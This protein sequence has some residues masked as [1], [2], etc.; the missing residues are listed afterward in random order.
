MFQ[1][2][3]PQGVHLSTIYTASQGHGGGVYI[4]SNGRASVRVTETTFRNN[5]ATEPRESHR[6]SINGGGVYVSV[7]G[8]IAIM[9]IYLLTHVTFLQ[10]QISQWKRRSCTCVHHWF[11][12]HECKQLHG[13]L[14]LNYWEREEPYRLMVAMQM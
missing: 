11:S 4:Y 10:T 13:Q 2:Q 7:T 12:G 8:D 6:N 9:V 1:C 3:L 5:S 14:C